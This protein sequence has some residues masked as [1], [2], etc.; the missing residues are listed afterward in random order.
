MEVHEV[1]KKPVKTSKRE[2]KEVI[3]TGRSYGVWMR[4]KALFVG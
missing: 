3:Y 1:G 4:E 2:W